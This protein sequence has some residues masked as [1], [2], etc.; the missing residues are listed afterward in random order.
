MYYVYAHKKEHRCYQLATTSR[1]EAQQ[2][3]LKVEADNFAVF[4][5]WRRGE[6][7][8]KLSK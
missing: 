5:C 6:T 8:L 7:P 1:E 2:L 3:I 4:A